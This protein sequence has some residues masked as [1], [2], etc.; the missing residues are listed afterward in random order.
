MEDDI[1]SVD[2]GDIV[3]SSHENKWV[4]ITPDYKKVLA[5]SERLSDLMRQVA[6]KDVIFHRVLPHDVSFAPVI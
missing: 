5:A 2:L 6:D 3:D 4:A 1:Q